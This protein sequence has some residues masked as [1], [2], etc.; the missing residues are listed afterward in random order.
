MSLA[1]PAPSRAAARGNTSLPVEVADATSAVAPACLTAA[2]STGAQ[3]SASG[4][5]RPGL[6]AFSSLSTKRAPSVAAVPSSAPAPMTTPTTGPP[7]CLARSRAALMAC[8]EV[9]RMP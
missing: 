9:E 5:A 7:W 6:S 1:M 3:V 8:R 2:A 4:W